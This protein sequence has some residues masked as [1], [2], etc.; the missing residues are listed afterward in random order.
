LVREK[1]KKKFYHQ[2]QGVTTAVSAHSEGRKMRADSVTWV[3][4]VGTIYNILILG[5]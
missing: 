2:I 4:Q 5:V 1:K 3:P